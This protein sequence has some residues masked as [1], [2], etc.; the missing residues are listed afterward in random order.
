MKCEYCMGTLSLEDENCPHCGR[1]NKHA[2]QHIRD[3]QRFQGEFEDTKK[4]VYA[5]TGKY[6][7]I[8]VRVVIIAILL[9]L[10]LAALIIGAMAWD[11]QRGIKRAGADRKYATYSK[12]MDEYLED[13]N[14]LEFN[15]F[16]LTK[17]ISYYEGAYS[18]DYR[19]VIQL[20]SNYASAYD[21]LY[22]YITFDENNNLEQQVD[23]TSNSL[24]YFY[25]YYLNE[26][27]FYTDL[28]GES[29]RYEQAAE[30]M[31]YN[32]ECILITYCGF[33][34]EEAK[35]MPELSKTKRAVL[36][37]EKLEARVKNE[38]E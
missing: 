22:S 4:Y 25:K 6:T 35:S 11:I 24:D 30:V 14:Y 17:G 18:E 19:L 20:C 31:K 1:P 34:E 3:M 15:Q 32:I 7:G 9:V 8:A 26:N 5:E 13:E 28:Y 38:Q 33:S 12:I 10:C 2:K 23:M 21:S 27:N 37:E 36:L 29:E 16:C